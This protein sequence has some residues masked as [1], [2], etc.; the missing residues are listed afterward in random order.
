MKKIVGSLLVVMLFASCL[1]QYECT[2]VVEFNGSYN[3]VITEDTEA[4]N[5]DGA[6]A[7]CELMNV[8]STS[9]S[10]LTKTCYVTGQ[11]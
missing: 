11:K 5:L 8:D 2:C 9:T 10:P 7:A 3:G 1:K 6:I 4:Y